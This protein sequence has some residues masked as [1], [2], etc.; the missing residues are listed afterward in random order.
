[1]NDFIASVGLIQLK[2]INLFNKKR[3]KILKNVS[4]R[5]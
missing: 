3:A 2:K 5:Y 4:Q 1:M